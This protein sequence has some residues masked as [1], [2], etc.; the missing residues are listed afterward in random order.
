MVFSELELNIDGHDYE[1]HNKNE[2]ALTSCEN[3]RSPWT[4]LGNFLTCLL[5]EKCNDSLNGSDKRVFV[6]LRVTEYKGI[7]WKP[8]TS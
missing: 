2:N 4:K 1:I 7:G 8:M 6:N 3:R 5:N